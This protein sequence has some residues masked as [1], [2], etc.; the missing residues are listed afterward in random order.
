[1]RSQQTPPP[2]V[3]PSRGCLLA[4]DLLTTED[5]MELLACGRTTIH[6]HLKAG[7]IPVKPFRIGNRCYWRSHAIKSWLATLAADGETAVQEVL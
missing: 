5:M 6:N 1:M 2:N 4:K 7:Y 3:P